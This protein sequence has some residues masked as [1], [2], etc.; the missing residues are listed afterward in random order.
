MRSHDM[1]YWARRGLKA[2]AFEPV[3]VQLF[4]LELILR[5]YRSVGNFLAS[6]KYVLILPPIHPTMLTTL[7]WLRRRSTIG[8]PRHGAFHSV[9]HKTCLNCFVRTGVVNHGHR[10][11]TCSATETPWRVSRVLYN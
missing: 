3:H 10:T 11:N 4:L 9:W 8:H 7:K 6:I 5:G 1:A 2:Q